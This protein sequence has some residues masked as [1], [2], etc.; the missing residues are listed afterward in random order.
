[1]SSCL[2][3]GSR[4]HLRHLPVG[5]TR[6]REAIGIRIEARGANRGELVTRTDEF[7]SSFAVRVKSF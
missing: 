2:E 7:S 5:S 6:G 3:T 1:M 4:G